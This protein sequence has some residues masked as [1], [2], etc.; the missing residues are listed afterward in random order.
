MTNRQDGFEVLW[1]LRHDLTAGTL[2]Q[3][4][5]DSREGYRLPD[6]ASHFRTYCD[7]LDSAAYTAVDMTSAAADGF[8]DGVASVENAGFKLTGHPSSEQA[9]GAAILDALITGTGTYFLDGEEQTIQV[10][11]RAEVKLDADY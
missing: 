7:T 9:I 4:R 2:K 6:L 8:R 11:D 5:F 10:M 1:S 3:Y